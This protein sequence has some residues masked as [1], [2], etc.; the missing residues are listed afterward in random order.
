MRLKNVM[1]ANTY[2]RGYLMLTLYIANVEKDVSMKNLSPKEAI[3]ILEEMR[4]D[5]PVPKAAVTQIK[6]NLALNMAINALNCSEIP[7]NSDTISR[8]AALNVVNEYLAR[9]C[10]YI[11]MPEDNEEY[12]AIRGLLVSVKMGLQ[13]VPKEAE[14]IK[15]GRWIVE[16]GVLYGHGEDAHY[17]DLWHCSECGRRELDVEGW[18][19]CPNCGAKMDGEEE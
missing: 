14:P 5:I 3:T 4:I 17:G 2:I 1:H 19:Y 15:R 10:R 16:H 7:N 13:R 6:R 11:A 18:D 12:A 8:Q 9:Y